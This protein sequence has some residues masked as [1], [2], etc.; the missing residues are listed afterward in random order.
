M[1]AESKWLPTTGGKETVVAP[2]DRFSIGD[3]LQTY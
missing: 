1:H 2:D 3:F